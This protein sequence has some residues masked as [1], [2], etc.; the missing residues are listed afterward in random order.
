MGCDDYPRKDYEEEERKKAKMFKSELAD[1]LIS[2]SRIPGFES[3]AEL[4]SKI[5]NMKTKD[6]YKLYSVFEIIL[7]TVHNHY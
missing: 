6:V 2:V 4:S 1:A 3:M 5:E 7:R